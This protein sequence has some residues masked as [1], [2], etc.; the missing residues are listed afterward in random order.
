M[1]NDIRCALSGSTW[2]RVGR[3]LLHNQQREIVR[4][5]AALMPQNEEIWYQERI[6]PATSSQKQCS[7]GASQAGFGIWTNC[8]DKGDS[9]V[10]QFLVDSP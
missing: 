3:G 5:R 1:L 2:C 6:A 7:R 10:V 8:R 9:E 4:E